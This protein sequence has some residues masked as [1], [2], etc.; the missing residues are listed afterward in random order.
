MMPGK[1]RMT[2][3]VLV[4]KEVEIKAEAITMHMYQGQ[5]ATKQ[6]KE[7]DEIPTVMVNAGKINETTTLCLPTE[8]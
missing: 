4:L 6:L 8:E 7:N 5:T 3:L 2:A 1:H